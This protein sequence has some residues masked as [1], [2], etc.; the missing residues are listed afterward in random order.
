M[1][2]D[3]A[4]ALIARL[5]DEGYEPYDYSGRA[6]YGERCVAVDLDSS[7]GLFKLGIDLMRSADG[8][9]L[10]YGDEDRLTQVFTDSM[11]RGI[12][13]Y[14]RFI[15]WPAGY[16]PPITRERLMALAEED[17]GDVG[18]DAVQFSC[19][20]DEDLAKGRDHCLE[21]IQPALEE[22]TSHD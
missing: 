6:M 20:T 2:E 18:V 15:Y 4:R 1:N 9:D 11:G 16:C 8:A 10:Y 14:W 19:L 22:M 17:Y 5:A 12:V 21:R 7:A 13:A 3:L